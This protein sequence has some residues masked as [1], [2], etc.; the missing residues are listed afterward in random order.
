MVYALLDISFFCAS[1]F[2]FCHDYRFMYIILIRTV[3]FKRSYALLVNGIV[4]TYNYEANT[5]ILV[6]E[7]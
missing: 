2:V 3:I 5:V 7:N 4:C 6:T 1:L